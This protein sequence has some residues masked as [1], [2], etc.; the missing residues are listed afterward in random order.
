[1]ACDTLLQSMPYLYISQIQHLLTIDYLFI[2][3]AIKSFKKKWK[4][5][6]GMASC[7]YCSVLYVP[8]F[9]P[10]PLAQAINGD[11]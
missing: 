5:Y 7:L 11:K 4:K 8:W 2:E 3:E 9:V 6:I 1:M 10:L